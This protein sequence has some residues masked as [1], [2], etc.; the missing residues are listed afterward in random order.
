[1]FHLNQVHAH[2]YY[3]ILEV[4]DVSTAPKSCIM[5]HSNQVH[6]HQYYVILEVS[7]NGLAVYGNS[8]NNYPF[9]CSYQNQNTVRDSENKLTRP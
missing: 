2:Q 8:I 5:F 6:A 1:M 7:D 4:S 3:V 9:K